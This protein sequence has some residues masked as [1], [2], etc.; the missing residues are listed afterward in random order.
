MLNHFCG[1]RVV[2]HF[3]DNLPIFSD[4]III[5]LLL[6]ILFVL[7]SCTLSSSCFAR[8]RM[9]ASVATREFLVHLDQSVAKQ[10][11]LPI[12]LPPM[13]LNRYYIA[14][15]VRLYSQETWR[16]VTEGRGIQLVEQYIQE[17]VSL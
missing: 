11:F 4:I 5:Q 14:E 12:L 15:G 9:S 16:Q 1:L 10:Q 7:L 2:C 13:C 6:L 17:V 8:G 3:V